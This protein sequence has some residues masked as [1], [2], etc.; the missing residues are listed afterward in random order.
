VRA[1]LTGGSGFAGH[2]L[3]KHLRESGDEVVLNAADVTDAASIAEAVAAAAPDVVYHLAALTDVQ[4]SWRDPALTLSVNAGGTLNVL[5][6]AARCSSSP[7]VLV[8][9]SS[10]VYGRR[11]AAAGVDAAG[12]STAEQQQLGYLQGAGAAVGDEAPALGEDAP[13]RPVS[14]YAA[15][16]VA[17]EYLAVQ[18]H[19]GR[20]LRAVRVR[21]FNHIG[22]GQS[23][24]FVV[25]ALARRIVEAE[26]SGADA[27]R[28]GNVAPARDFTDVRDVVRAYR[29]LALEADGGEV[30]NV[31]SGE[32]LVIG[33]IL[34]R[35]VR[36]AGSD[37][38]TVVDP[39]LFR[40]ADTDVPAGDA[41][42]LAALT[43]WKPEIPLDDTLADV[44]AYWRREAAPDTVG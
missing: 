26:R 8:V 25:S 32:R 7:T 24:A 29:L 33:A 2:C 15:S 9:S 11:K 1:Y 31:C 3:A 41:G 34:E 4:R 22:P 17:A 38:G 19:L 13:L 28:V 21:P 36:I 5:E 14:P 44:L 10:E 35:L 30:Y 18:A 6:A 42:R 23:D 12:R 43:G 39:Q 40:P 37:V 20:G 27:I 16:K